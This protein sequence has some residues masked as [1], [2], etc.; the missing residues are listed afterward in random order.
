MRWSTNEISAKA[1]KTVAAHVDTRVAEGVPVLVFNPLAW[2]RAGNVTVD[3]QMPSPATDVSVLDTHGAVLPSE[4]LSKDASTSTSPPA[5][6]A[7]GCAFA[8]LRGAAGG[9]GEAAVH[10]RSEGERNDA[11]KRG[12]RVVIDPKNGCITSLYDKKAGFETL[13]EGSC[14]N[15]LQTF[16]DT[17]KDYDAWNIDPGT[18]DVPPTRITDADSVEVVERGPCG[19]RSG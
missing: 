10:E 17:P 4:V 7:A 19:R 3:V 14:G 9:A 12:A 8:G 2:A 6:G 15:Q 13:A 5:G 11:R 16:K 18:L 1:L